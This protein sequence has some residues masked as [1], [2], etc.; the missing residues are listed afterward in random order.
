MSGFKYDNTSRVFSLDP[1]A[2]S[3]LPLILPILTNTLHS[4][5][6]HKYDKSREVQVFT[7]YAGN[8]SGNRLPI[9]SMSETLHGCTVAAFLKNME[10]KIELSN[11]FS[12]VNAFIWP[13]HHAQN[14]ELHQMQ[15]SHFNFHEDYVTKSLAY[16]MDEKRRKLYLNFD[17]LPETLQKQKEKI[18]SR[19]IPHGDEIT[20]QE[21]QDFMNNLKVDE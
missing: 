18:I 3:R 15:P 10:D 6:P 1:S 11:D 20:E 14:M 7:Q 19:I 16:T 13:N 5:N 12:S 9:D 2:S 4:Y 17:S 21:V 8:F